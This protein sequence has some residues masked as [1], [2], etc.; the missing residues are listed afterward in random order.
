MYNPSLKSM[1]RVESDLDRPQAAARLAENSRKGKAGLVRFVPIEN[2]VLEVNRNIYFPLKLK[3]GKPTPLGVFAHSP[4]SERST[5]EPKHSLL[6]ECWPEHKRSALVTRTN[7]A[8]KQGRIYRDIDIKGCGY[9]EPDQLSN[10]AP[11]EVG[12]PGRIVEGNQ[13]NREGLLEKDIALYDFEISEQCLKWGIRTSRTVAIVSLKEIVGAGQT[14]QIR[15]YSRVYPDRRLPTN[16]QP[17]VEIRAFGTKARIEDLDAGKPKFSRLILNDAK[18]MVATEIKQNTRLTDRQ[19]LNWFAETLGRNL[20]LLHKMGWTHNFL[21]PHNVTLDCRI[22]DL[23]GVEKQ[24]ASI[25]FHSDFTRAEETLNTFS[26][27]ISDLRLRRRF[28][29]SPYRLHESFR[30]AYNKTRYAK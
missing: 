12:L 26:K 6:F 10:R 1:S 11:M 30:H 4:L 17:V 13:N 5:E 18:A 21:Y 28:W 20:G 15:R 9:L 8:D 7:F 3:K 24:P 14:I 27:I 29:D 2:Q 19:Y 23:D 22:V 16:F 25:Q